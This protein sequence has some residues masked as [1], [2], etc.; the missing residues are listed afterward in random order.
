MFARFLMISLFSL[1]IGLFLGCGEDFNQGQEETEE[2]E[3]GMNPDGDVM[4][5]SDIVIDKDAEGAE[6][7]GDSA[8]PK[9]KEEEKTEDK[10]NE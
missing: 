7:A 6:T 4:N 10:K 5:T 1:S 3:T 2:A 9:D 8:I